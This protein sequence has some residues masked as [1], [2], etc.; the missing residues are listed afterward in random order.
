MTPQQEQQELN[1]IFNGT[2][3]PETATPENVFNRLIVA[4]PLRILAFHAA[5]N[6]KKV[7]S[8]AKPIYTDEKKLYNAL[9]TAYP[10]LIDYLRS[11]AP[12][13]YQEFID[14]VHF[15]I[16]GR[17]ELVKRLNNLGENKPVKIF[18]KLLQG[19]ATNKLT[20][21]NSTKNKK[22]VADP[23]TGTLKISREDFTVKLHGYLVNRGLRQSAHQLLDALLEVYTNSGGHSE[24]ITL[25]LKNYMEIRG[26]NDEKSARQQVK[27][28]LET[29]SQ[30]RIDFSQNLRGGRKNDYFE[31]GL[32][33]PS[34]GIKNGV[35]TVNLD[36]VFH[37]LLGGYKPMPYPF[38]LWKLSEN[39]NPH[40][41]YFLRKICEMKHMN[42]GKA[43][44]DT[45]AVL[46]L[47]ESSPNMPT[48]EEITNRHYGER[49]IDPFERDMNA[50][51]EVLTW[52]YCHSNNEPLTDDELS[53]F[54]VE[55]FRKLYVKIFWRNYP[56]QKKRKNEGKTAYRQE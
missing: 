15:S 53:D 27:E 42:S 41:Y 1:E 9:I 50:L 31:L 44:E 34:K 2:F 35:I 18:T 20:K 56:D 13:K 32:I 8:L 11:N 49:I 45:I 22:A 16:K 30:I 48:I 37:T 12:D 54:T 28:D 23:N 46:T 25:P 36:S 29:L 38:L 10:E 51:D 52:Q 47:L 4:I 3:N 19:T 6:D 39:H 26:I 5:M 24:L 14:F 7:G 17:E 55:I 43:N 33:Q 40:A 21:I